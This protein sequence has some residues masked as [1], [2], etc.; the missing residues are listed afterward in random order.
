MYL[1]TLQILEPKI[2]TDLLWFLPKHS[3]NISE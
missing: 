1:A 3:I 2:W